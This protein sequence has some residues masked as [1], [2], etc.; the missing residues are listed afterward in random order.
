MILRLRG[1][2]VPVRPRRADDPFALLGLDPQADLTD[3]EVRAVWRRIASSTHPDRVDGGDPERFGAAT[4]A[5]TDLRTR[6]GRGEARAALAE[7]AAGRAAGPAAQVHATRTSAAARI[8]SRVRQGRPVRLVLR[9]LGAC[10]AGAS[11]LLAAWP[12]PAGPA[13]ATGA[14]TWLLLTIRRDLSPP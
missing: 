8:L 11:G 3:D 4:A 7:Q 2:R 10:A 1:T 12:G 6:S 14:L 5:Y 9:V 13:L